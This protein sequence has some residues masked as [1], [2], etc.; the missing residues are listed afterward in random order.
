MDVLDLDDQLYSSE[1][2]H[3]GKLVDR[4]AS[5]NATGKTV[6]VY[7]NYSSAYKDGVADAYVGTAAAR[8]TARN[9]GRE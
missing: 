1:T 8:N 7:S 4:I 6:P 5:A 3:Q 9:T 2:Y